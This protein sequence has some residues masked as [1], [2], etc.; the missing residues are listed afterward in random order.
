MNR[1]PRVGFVVVS[2]LVI[3]AAILSV[4]IRLAL[5]EG[6]GIRSAKADFEELSFSLAGVKGAGDMADPGLRV[7]LSRH[8]AASPTI[9]LALVTERGSGL[10]WRI[11]ERSPYLPGA[12]NFVADPVVIHPD[13]VTLLLSAPLRGDSSGKL[14]L[15]ALYVAIPQTAVFLAFRDAALGLGLWMILAIVLILAFGRK[16][17]ATWRPA[18]A[19]VAAEAP[20]AGA[21][22]D[23]A[24]DDAASGTAADF[25]VDTGFETEADRLLPKL[26]DPIDDGALMEAA[27]SARLADPRGLFSPLS[28]LGWE[29]YLEDRLEAELSRS[30]SFEQDLSLLLVAFEGIAPGDPTYALIA[31]T[32][33]EFFSFK[34]LAFERGPEGFAVILP[35]LDADH[36]LR[37]AEEFHRKVTLLIRGE[38]ASA[39]L[40]SLP[41]CIGLSSRA[42]RL[43]EA[44]RLLGEAA[45]A[46][47]RAREEGDTKI[48]AFKPDP[49]KYRLYLAS[50]GI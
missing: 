9:L 35:N 25:G 16:P 50:K 4:V 12:E 20:F 32:I 6:E 14:V 17:D 29:S 21:A 7:K 39:P 23:K 43:V 30:A 46:L 44:P 19:G 27:T 26:A 36:G 45:I 18:K 42:G 24:P 15:E 10:L 49:D 2:V 28:G 8:Y 40:D 3:V 41:L 22:F 37:M 11:P 38:G 34:D 31:R 1:K 33:A 13:R 5:A 48:L 47:D